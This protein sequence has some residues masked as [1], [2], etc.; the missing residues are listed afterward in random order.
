ML[1]V[2]LLNSYKGMDQ[3]FF[4]SPVIVPSGQVVKF[5]LG[6]AANTTL[7]V[8][9][10]VGGIVTEALVYRGY[11]IVNIGALA[12]ARVVSIKRQGS[13]TLA[14]IQPEYVVA[15]GGQKVSI[16]GFTKTLTR[17]GCSGNEEKSLTLLGSTV[18]EIRYDP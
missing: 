9:D 5:E 8:N 6:W 11:T 13:K 15:K 12:H 2:V 3:P 16:N 18:E 1:I 4:S 10:Y 7:H 14:E 17:C